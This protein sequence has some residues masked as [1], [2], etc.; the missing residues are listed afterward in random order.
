VKACEELRRHE[1]LL[2]QAG[3]DGHNDAAP[4]EEDNVSSWLGIDMIQCYIPPKQ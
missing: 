3:K 1:E 2:E 4:S